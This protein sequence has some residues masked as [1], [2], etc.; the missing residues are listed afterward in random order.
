MLN[1]VGCLIL[2]LF[3]AFSVFATDAISPNSSTVIGRVA[4]VS[5]KVFIRHNNGTASTRV[6][7][8]EPLKELDQLIT[9]ANGYAKVYYFDDSIMDIGPNSTLTIEQFKQNNETRNIAFKMLYGKIRTLVTK[10]LVGDSSYRVS[11]PV[12]TMGVRGTEFVVHSYL[13]ENQSVNSLPKTDITCLEGKVAIDI[14]KSVGGNTNQTILITPGQSFAGSLTNQAAVQFSV[15]KLTVPQLQQMSNVLP[16]DL[17]K[18]FNA[19]KPSAASANSVQQLKDPNDL[20]NRNLKN[21]LN[22]NNTPQPNQPSTNQQ[23]SSNQPAMKLAPPPAQMMNTQMNQNSMIPS[24]S[25]AGA[26]GGGS[27]GGAM[28]TQRPP[29][30]I[31]IKPPPGGM[32]PGQGPMPQNCHP[33]TTNPGQIIC[34]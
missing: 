11:T 10:K 34:N 2:S 17:S 19:S 26:A 27:A 23:P 25:A 6:V 18:V 28:A 15:S 20:K 22:N 8:N 5:G 33:S 29:N 4:I 30:M 13:P 14:N 3:S 21:N 7:S 16:N 32:P 12:S 31:Q 1:V 24:N 9:E